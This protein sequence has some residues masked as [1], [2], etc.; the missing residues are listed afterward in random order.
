L[1]E[2]PARAP[3]TIGNEKRRLI[4][5]KFK[6]GRLVQLDAK[7]LPL[8]PDLEPL[9]EPCQLKILEHQLRPLSVAGATKHASIGGHG[10]KRSRPGRIHISL[11]ASRRKRETLRFPMLAVSASAGSTIAVVFAVD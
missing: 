5:E 4:F 9:P 11:M 3:R 6:G 1:S 8:R 2:A 7:E 10:D